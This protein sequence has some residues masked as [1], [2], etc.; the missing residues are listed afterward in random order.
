MENNKNLENNKN[1]ENNNNKL[2]LIKPLI[3][4]AEKEPNNIV[5]ELI[6]QELVVS[7]FIKYSQT[8][9]VK[10]EF[11]IDMLVRLTGYPKSMFSNM[12]AEDFMECSMKINRFFGYVPNN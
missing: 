1:I 8:D 6:F 5:N 11:V 3:N 10:V 12:G 9:F 7:D 4:P 2:I